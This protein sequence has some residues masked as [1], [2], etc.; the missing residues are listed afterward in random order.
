M[1]ISKNSDRIA[2]NAFFMYIR[3]FLMMLITLYT[4]RVTLN[5]LGISDYGI[6]NIVGGVVTMFSFINSSMA[7]SDTVS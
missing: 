6:Y 3:M 5:C 7:G 2:K 4:S 1:A